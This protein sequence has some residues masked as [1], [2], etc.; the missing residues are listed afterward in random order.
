MKKTY[1]RLN[2][3]ANLILFC[4]IVTGLVFPQA[5]AWTD[6]LPF[7]AETSWET[8]P[9]VMEDA[10]G[11]VWIVWD[12]DRIMLQNDLFY[13]TSTD[14]GLSWGNMFILTSDYGVDMMPALI[15]ASN[16]SIWLVWAS[17]RNGNFDIFYRTSSNG[18][19][20]WSDAFQITTDSRWDTYPAITEDA[21]GGIWVLWQRKVATSTHTI[22]CTTFNGTAWSP[23]T[24]LIADLGTNLNPAIVRLENGSIWL[25]WASNRSG[26][27][28][29]FCKTTS[30]NG[31]SWSDPFPLTTDINWD[32]TPTITQDINGSIWIAWASNR[33]NGAQNDIYCQTSPDHGLSWS[34]ITPLTT[35]SEEDMN[36]SISAVS[37]GRIIVVWES[38][39][40]LAFNIYYK[41]LYHNVA[42]T[43]VWASVVYPSPGYEEKRTW[44]FENNT[45]Y[46]NINI[47]NF[48]YE[49]ERYFNVTVYHD[50][51]VIEEREIAEAVLPDETVTLSGGKY[52]FEWD[53]TGFEPGYYVISGMSDPVPGELDTSDNFLTG[54]IIRIRKTGDANGDDIIDLFDA[55]Q[56]IGAF[57]VYDTECDF[58]V[59]G[60]INLYDALILSKA[61]ESETH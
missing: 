25:V 36:P 51:T 29:I 58:N 14:G 53:T 39:R 49:I 23:E 43:G 12:S 16:G 6:P 45:L 26:N 33:P 40:D 4:I 28:D 9:A 61:F 47:T 7:T 56:T 57:L 27:Y 24:E 54:G 48:G 3:T 35:N 50:S 30:N 1:S 15:Q 46:V 60:V 11:K 22:W 10:D 52:G 59:D 13:K 8:D 55:L 5:K 19:G 41:I 42:V 17:D 21:E 37:D 38:T 44:V 32:T 20:T 34:P 2:K 31:L 18:G